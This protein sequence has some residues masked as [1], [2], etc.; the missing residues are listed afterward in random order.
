MAKNLF[1]GHSGKSREGNFRSNEVLI[2]GRKIYDFTLGHKTFFVC[3]LEV[4]CGKV[5]KVPKDVCFAVL[6]GIIHP[7]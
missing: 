7:K 3:F 4:F 1:L 2:G 5:I 6:K